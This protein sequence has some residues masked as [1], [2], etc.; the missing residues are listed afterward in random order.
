MRAAVFVFW[1]RSNLN[2]A[3][4]LLRAEKHCP[5]SD[6][7]FFLQLFPA[8]PGTTFSASDFHALNA[9]SS[10]QAL[11]SALALQSSQREESS[12]RK[13][14]ARVDGTPHP[15]R[16]RRV[17]SSPI[18]RRRHSSKKPRKL[19]LTRTAI[20]NLCCAHPACC[21]FRDFDQTIKQPCN[22]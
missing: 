10:A 3:K 6:V 4:G 21:T 1:R 11:R 20:S 14:C 8:A 12:Q 2:S 16:G 22:E 17:A 5:R 15:R 19:F 13:L 9:S 18:T 7:I